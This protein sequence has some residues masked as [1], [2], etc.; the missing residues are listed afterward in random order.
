MSNNL[1]DVID[2]KML[3]ELQYL[4]TDLI[5]GDE[6][7]ITRPE[8]RS[9]DSKSIQIALNFLL[10]N[11][12]L[13][14][15]QKAYLATNSWRV[16]YRDEPPR[17]N[18]FITEKYIGRAAAHT[19]SRI[20][21]VFEAFMDPSKPY[22]NLILY[23]H[24][25]WGK[26]VSRYNARI[27]K[28]E[29]P[30][31]AN[32]IKVGDQVCTPN[33][34]VA[35]VTAVKIWE[36][37]EFANVHFADGRH[38]RCGLDHYFKAAKSTNGA[39]WDKEQRKYV[40]D[41]ARSMPCW[42]IITIREIIKDVEKNPKAR[43][44]I[45]MPKAVY[46]NEVNHFIPPYALGALLGDG[47]LDHEELSISGDDK[48]I[49]EKVVASGIGFEQRQLC[50]NSTVLY[51]ARSLIPECKQE[52]QRLGLLNS[53]S[54][55]KFIPDEYLYDSVENRIALLQ[56]LMDTDGSAHKESGMGVYYTTSPMLRDNI[57]TLVRGLGGQASWSVRAKE[58][59]SDANYDQYVVSISFPENSF[60]LFS[61]PRKQEWIDKNFNRKRSRS[62]TKYLYITNIERIENEDGLC[63]EIDDEERLFLVDD[64]IVT[65]NSYL[66]TLIN[67]YIAIHLSMMR[68]PYKFFGLNPASVLS[69]LLV[70]FSLKKSSELLL[71]P[72]IAILEQSPFFE[73]VHTRDGMVKK[74]QDF[75]RQTKID[76]IYWTTAVPTSAIQ[77]SNG[78]NFKLVSNVQN[79]LGLSVVSGTMT[80]LSFFRDAGR[81]DEYIMRV[82]NDLKNRIDTRMKGN[83]FGRSILDSSPNS[84]DSPIDDYV[85]NHARKDPTNYIVDGSQWKWAPEEYDM[86][87]TFKVFIGG[88]G[89]PPR[90]LE[91]CE[92]ADVISPEKLIDVPYKLKQFFEDDL[93]K[94]LKDRAGIPS[95]SADSLIYDYSKIERIFDTRLRSLYTHIEAN[96]EAAP[97]GLIWNQVAPWFFRQKA[98]RTEFWYKPHLPRCLAVDQSISGD[99]SAIAV[100][101]VERMMGSDEQMFVVDM[102]IPIAPM[103]K[104][105]NL[106]AIKF[107]IEDL[108]NLGNMSITHVS[109]DQF[110]SE[111]SIQ[112]LKS[113]GF[114]CER[115]SVDLT[116]DPYFNLLSL[117]ETNRLVSGRNIY[118]KNNLKSLKLVK[119][120]TGDKVRYKVDHEDSRSV[121]TTGN[122]DWNKSMIGFFA[123][124]TT[125]AIAAACDLLRKY[126]PVAYDA[127]DPKYL[128]NLVSGNAEHGEAEDRTKAFLSSIGARIVQ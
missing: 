83:Y 19:Y 87:H 86:S 23:P 69:Q 28:P 105:I 90:I 113:V 7:V 72:L 51:Y 80:E 36:N 111:S 26:F 123:K 57:T 63:I 128:E 67:I 79:L 17:P 31:I 117:I 114:E 45:P 18:N 98:G 125:D 93:Y 38:V 10:D 9:L 122:E 44:F 20:K 92:E 41:S 62:K 35:N 84:L 6:S 81:T 106:D 34:G 126:H 112:Y 124:D 22:R 48:L 55:T 91:S 5:S 118:I 82:F 2:P 120:K 59:L 13:D 89:Q 24:I 66:A 119:I 52:L 46:H 116:T 14:D 74:D 65:H 121:I 50:E 104:R 127:W 96:T 1:I 107:F 43:W 102:V 47:H 64:Y 97:R 73:K 78:A 53:R 85:V 37:E 70:S 56:G 39:Y 99:V 30:V 61:L 109:F 110:Q 27:Y 71:E 3:N 21:D 103:G 95:G 75:E 100:V 77:M 8:Y 12:M 25:G 40:Y 76:K 54:A 32:D 60:P 88:K 4:L 68:N 33:G 101:H 11:P 58:R 29:G 15:S 42:K 108:R 16:N 49:I 115:L 94:A